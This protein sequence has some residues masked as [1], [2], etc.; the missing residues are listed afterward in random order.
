MKKLLS[1]SFFSLLCLGALQAQLSIDD[2]NTDYRIDFDSTMAGVNE[3]TFDGTGFTPSPAAGQLNSNA[4]IVAGLSEGDM[5]YGDTETASDFAKGESPG[6]IF[7][8]GFYAF[9][10]DTASSNNIAAGLQPT[11]SDWTPGT[12][13]L[14]IVNNTDSV[15]VEI[16]IA[17]DIYVNNDQER[18]NSFNFSFSSDNNTYTDSSSMDYTSPEASDMDSWTATARS[19]TLTGLAIPHTGNFYFQWTGS[20]ESGGG[21]RDEFAID[22]IVISAVTTGAAVCGVT[23]IDGING[24]ACDDNSTPSDISDD[25]FITDVLVS[26]IDAP[27]IGSLELFLASDTSLLASVAVASTDSA[28]GHAFTALQFPADGNDIGLLARFSEDTLCNLNDAAAVAGVASCPPVNIFALSQVDSC[29]EIDFDNAVEGVNI[30]Q[31]TGAGFNPIP[32]AGQI[33]SN[34]FI[35]SGFSDPDINYGD[36]ALGDFAR[37]TSGGSVTSAGIYAFTVGAGDHALGVQPT[38]S[39]WT[40]G[41]IHMRFINTS[42]S[43]ITDLNISYD[44][45]VYN[46]GGRSN[47]FNFFHSTDG[48]S[49]TYEPASDFQSPEAADGSPSWN[50]TTISV[51]LSGLSIADSTIYYFRWEGAD[52]SG[53][54]SRDEFALDNIIITTGSSCIDT[55]ACNILTISSDSISACDDNSTP[56]DIDDDTFTADVVVTYINAAATGSMDVYVNGEASPSITVDVSML[57]SDSMHVFEDQLFDA[58]GSEVS[59]KGCLFV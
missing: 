49:Y 30:D 7:S 25:F 34:T 50:A 36:A 12:M 39:E 28:T 31:F 11:G 16:S 2:G 5:D 42:D 10:T 27:A 17:Y 3:G 53:G 18:A 47:S 19:I 58:D 57:D 40:P 38:G 59:L 21:S 55:N 48:V 33:N 35:A 45:Y 37:G 9:N 29:F 26:F 41:N 52:S 1:L 13:G 14:K 46:D 20:D 43:L 56:N 51:S 44:V 24:S 32:T 8:G 15:I 54:G 4:L 22:N 23:G 6:G